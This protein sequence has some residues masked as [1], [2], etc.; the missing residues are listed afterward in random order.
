MPSHGL[1]PSAHG[2]Q[3]KDASCG[4]VG[5]AASLTMGSLTMGSLYAGQR[6]VR[7][8]PDPARGL[9]V[10]IQQRGRPTVGQSAGSG[11]PRRARSSWQHDLRGPPIL[12]RRVSAQ[13]DDSQSEV[14]TAQVVKDP[15]RRTRGARAEQ[16]SLHPRFYPR[17]R[18]DFAE[19]HSGDSGIPRQRNRQRT[20]CPT[21]PP[22]L[23]WGGAK[24]PAP[25]RNSC[26]YPGPRK[27]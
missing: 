10:G 14:P 22:K 4:L 6:A 13:G 17:A 12:E 7:G 25:G 3:A 11:D 5:Q 2:R 15:I 27:N 1:V 20:P 23:G 18:P 24:S 8:S 26:R 16:T 19:T 21:M 9:T